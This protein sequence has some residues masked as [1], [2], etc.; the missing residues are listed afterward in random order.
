MSLLPATATAE[1]WQSV[2]SKIT[3]K[4][5]TLGLTSD[6]SQSPNYKMTPKVVGFRGMVKVP[7]RLSLISGK[8]KI[9]SA[10][11]QL[12]FDDQVVCNY[13]P[14]S[15]GAKEFYFVVCS[16]GARPGDDVDVR[17]KIT[18]KLNHAASADAS[19]YASLKIVRADYISYGIIFPFLKAEEG[20]VL[21]FN[22]SAWVATNPSEIEGLRGEAGPMGPQGEMGPMG[23]A[24]PKGDQGEPGV[25]GAVGP[26]G[27][28]GPQGEQGATGLTG[29]VGPQG[30]QGPAGAVGPQ[31]PKGDTGAVGPQG[32]QGLQGIAGPQGEKGDAGPVGPQGPEGLKGDKGDKG[33]AG[34]TEVAY[35]RDEKNPGVSAGSCVA[36]TWGVR[37]LNVLG[38]TNSFISLSNSRFTLVPGKYFVQISVPTYASGTSQARLVVSSNSGVAL[39]H[40]SIASSHP[41]APSVSHSVIQGEIIVDQNSTFEVQQNCQRSRAGDGFGVAG[42]FGMEVYTQAKIIKTE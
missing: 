7:T 2:I 40:G 6:L 13:S 34:L 33:D 22:G 37:T 26:Q 8:G 31:G 21:M 1:N 10:S 4:Q 30:P 42:G 25:A 12:I 32:P 17:N 18:L 27:P 5:K 36:G 19:L 41:S 9:H 35:L 3:Y 39:L 28:Q 24:G 29:A 14:K 23:P 11:G 16:D 20:D 15:N 38:G